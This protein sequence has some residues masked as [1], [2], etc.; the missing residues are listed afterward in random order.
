MS[1]LSHMRLF[2]FYNIFILILQSIKNLLQTTKVHMH[3][4]TFFFKK[5]ELCAGVTYPAPAFHQDVV[6]IMHRHGI[7]S[8]ASAATAEVAASAAP[9]TSATPEGTARV[10]GMRR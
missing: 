3:C 6:D 8:P 5:T 9:A 1:T 2:L 7:G 10:A 4:S